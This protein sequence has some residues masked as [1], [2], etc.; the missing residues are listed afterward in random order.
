MSSNAER[1][2]ASA[3]IV[4]ALRARQQG[5][6]E[7]D[8]DGA[9]WRVVPAEA[10]HRAGL[11]VGVT[12]DRSRAR[13]VGRELRRQQALDLALRALG[14]RDHTTSELEQRLSQRGVASAERE[15]TLAVLDRAGLV[16]DARFAAD[17]AALLVERASG[18]LL[19][20]DDL[21]RRGVTPEVVADVLAAL[22]PEADRAER[23]VAARGASV[24]T[25]R[26]LSA[27]GFSEAAL[28]SLVAHLE[29]GAVG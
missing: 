25:L 24:R 27:K 15:R 16:C 28:E 22:E 12:L 19:I 3:P 18:D 13:T 23:I 14:R 1:A 17:R 11:A 2:P 4:T 7:I 9:H 29:D 21:E 10:V 6:V 26:A 8:L 5:R 20:A